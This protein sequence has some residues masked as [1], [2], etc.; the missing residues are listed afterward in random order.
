MIEFVN[1]SAETWFRYM[2]SATLQAVGLALLVLTV[3]SLGRRV[4]PAL[5]HALLMLA[6]LKFA[7]PPT[8][9]LPTGLF[10]RIN[11]NSSTEPALAIPYF[12]PIAPVVE[13]ALW[14]PSQETMTAMPAAAQR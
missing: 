14:P 2:T 3:V 4:S 8:L 9:S 10:S 6:L 1:S 7:I 13:D 5:R 11:P 12:A